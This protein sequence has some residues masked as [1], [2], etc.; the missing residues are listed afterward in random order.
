VESA[1]LGYTGYVGTTLRE[2]ASFDR[3]YNSQN[4]ATIRGK[5][6]GLVV[7]AAAPAAKWKANQDPAGDLANIQQLMNHL[8]TITARQFV[9]ISTVDVFKMPPPADESTVIQPNSLDAYGR[10]RY[11][12]EG[13]VQVQFPASV[14]I[15]LPGLFGTGLRKNFLFDMIHRG[16]SEWTHA[17][18]TFQFYNMAHLWADI[19]RVLRAS[20]AITLVHFATE[21]VRAADVAR[22]AFNASYTHV[23]P[24][25]PVHYDLRTVHP[26]LW[27]RD[28]AYIATASE[29]LDQIRAFAA[30]E[31]AQL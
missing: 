31:R 7:C 3:L 12:L 23:T 15:R 16:N 8:S 5:E 30:A 13:F 9:L 2:Q 25:A 18:S 24:N 29:V 6:F 19:E 17:D 1:L 11:L 20:P 10:N 22:H 4:I 28:G 21:P 27:G 26:D 14:I